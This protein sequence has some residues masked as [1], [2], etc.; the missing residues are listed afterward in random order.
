MKNL[1]LTILV[2]LFGVAVFPAEAE[3]VKI[4]MLKKGLP[5]KVTVRVKDPDGKPLS[6]ASVMFCFVVYNHR[7]PNTVVARTDENGMATGE[8]LANDEIV[9]HIEKPGWYRPRCRHKLWGPGNGYQS[10]RWEPWNPTLDITMYPKINRRQA[11][12]FRSCYYEH[13]EPNVAYGFDML[14]KDIVPPGRKEETADFQFKGNG[15]K[16]II[17]C[18]NQMG[19]MIIYFTNSLDVIFQ[20][21]G[22]G[23]IKM[24]KH[25]DSEFKF[26]YLA[27]ETGYMQRLQLYEDF[28][29]QR[30]EGKGEP[31]LSDKEYLIFRISRI[32]EKSGETKRY[33]GIITRLSGTADLAGKRDFEIAYYLNPDPEDRNIEYGP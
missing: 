14:E 4:T 32:D 10:G 5:A 13:L 22:D 3:D 24:K 16:I 31:F 11:P 30:P 27:P 6:N 20:N 33:Y 7:E 19:S 1:L 17:S 29:P 15:Q 8:A 28:S 18:E 21:N 23:V 12:K 25:E 2:L 26:T 9:I